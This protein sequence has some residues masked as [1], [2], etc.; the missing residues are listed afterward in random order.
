MIYVND[1]PKSHNR[2]NSKSQFADDAAPWAIGKNV[3]FAAKPLRKDVRK[4]TKWCAK[5]RIKLNPEKKRGHHILQVLF[6]LKF[7]ES[8]KKKAVTGWYDFSHVKSSKM[9]SFDSVAEAHGLMYPWP[10]GENSSFA[11]EVI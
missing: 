5:W 10:S 7:S 8:R 11:W 9:F 1:L 2:Q 6:R 3:Q 4:L